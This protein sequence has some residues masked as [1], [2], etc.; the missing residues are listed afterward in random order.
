MAEIEFPESMFDRVALERSVVKYEKGAE[1]FSQGGPCDSN[2][3]RCERSNQ[4]HRH[5]RTRQGGCD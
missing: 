4:A 5:L 2:I 1:V 3:L